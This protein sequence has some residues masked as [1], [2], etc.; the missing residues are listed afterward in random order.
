[1]LTRREIMVGAMAAAA[2]V[3]ARTAHAKASQPST[4]VN[5]EVPAAATRKKILVDNPVRLYGF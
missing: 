3:R 1:M 5:F 4:P 2:I